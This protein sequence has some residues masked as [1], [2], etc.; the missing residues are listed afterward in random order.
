MNKLIK[1]VTKIFVQALEDLISIFKLITLYIR[2]TINV[3][4]MSRSKDLRLDLGCSNSQ[5][6]G[7]IG[8]DLTKGSNLTWDLRW[9]IPFNS[10]SVESIKSDHFF[11]HLNIDDLLFV[12][13]ECYRV[14]KKG[15]ELNFTVPHLDP[16]LNAYIDNDLKFLKEKISDIPLKYNKI[17]N[18]PFDLIMWLL[19]RNG[20]HKVFFDSKSIVA[21]L[22]HVGFKNIIIR[23]YNKNNDINKRFSSIYVVATK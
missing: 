7:Y 23:K 15:S 11:E 18:N 19:Y 4:K 22:E 16:Y 1:S 6:K 8:I 2:G 14:L 13:S 10:D 21:K 17:Y 20:E 12:L 9:G 5:K 3:Q